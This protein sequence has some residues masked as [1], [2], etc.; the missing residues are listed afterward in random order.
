M[1][2]PLGV[3][4][5]WDFDAF[6]DEF[7]V[8]INH[9]DQ[10]SMEFEMIGIDPAIANA[11]RRILLAEVP[12]V[13]IEHVFIVNNTSIIQVAADFSCQI[14]VLTSAATMQQ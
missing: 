10:H 8:I 14:Q 12:A 1:Y 2:L 4:N 6:K 7:Q 9:M 13:A 3:D 11:I 5:G